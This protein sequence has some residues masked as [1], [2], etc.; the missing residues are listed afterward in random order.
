MKSLWNKDSSSFG[1][2]FADF[3]LSKRRSQSIVLLRTSGNHPE[4]DCHR[5]VIKWQNRVKHLRQPRSSTAFDP[6]EVKVSWKFAKYISEKNSKDMTVFEKHLCLS[7]ISSEIL[8]K[9]RGVLTSRDVY[10]K[11][12]TAA[13]MAR[14]SNFHVWKILQY[15]NILTHRQPIAINTFM[16]SWP[17]N[18]VLLFLNICLRLLVACVMSTLATLRDYVV[19]IRSDSRSQNKLSG[20]PFIVDSGMIF[21]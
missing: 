19:A 10:L 5:V 11:L 16:G 9:W 13:R 8:N 4:I 2:N 15:S 3:V 18:T 12:V 7:F 6:R 1:I 14:L 17:A 21:N 20:S